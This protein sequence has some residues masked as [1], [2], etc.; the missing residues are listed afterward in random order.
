MP[1]EHSSATTNMIRDPVLYL[2]EILNGCI[3]A[4]GEHALEAVLYLW[5]LQDLEPGEIC[6]VY[7]YMDCCR[8]DNLT[9]KPAESSPQC[10]GCVAAGMKKRK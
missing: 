4:L 8:E 5:Q 7:M 2:V 9:T 6:E 3:P 1:S 10:T